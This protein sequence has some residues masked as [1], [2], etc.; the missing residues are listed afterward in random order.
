[1]SQRDTSSSRDYPD[2]GSPRSR[3]VSGAVYHLPRSVDGCNEK[4]LHFA[5]GYLNPNRLEEEQ[6]RKPVKSVT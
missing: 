3:V 1:M 2:I 5:L 4:R 6:A